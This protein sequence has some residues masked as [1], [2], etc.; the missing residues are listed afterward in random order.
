MIILAGTDIEEEC[1]FAFLERLAKKCSF[2]A[3]RKTPVH[4]RTDAAAVCI[5]RKNTQ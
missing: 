5:R 3:G 1:S 2:A 4:R